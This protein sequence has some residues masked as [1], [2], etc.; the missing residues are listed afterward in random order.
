MPNPDLSK[1]EPGSTR[2]DRLGYSVAVGVLV[3]GG[4]LARTPILNWISGPSIVITCVIVVGN[5]Q[6]RRARQREEKTANPEKSS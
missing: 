1:S 5:L 4:A 3:I 6:D 2:S